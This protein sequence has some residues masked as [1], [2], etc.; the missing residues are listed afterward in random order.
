MSVTVYCVKTE[1][2]NGIVVCRDV[3]VLNEVFYMGVTPRWSKRYKPGT[4]MLIT[5]DGTYLQIKNL[6]EYERI[7]KPFGFDLFYT[8]YL[9]NTN[10]IDRIEPSKHGNVAFFKGGGDITAPVSR[11]KTDEYRHLIRGPLS[12][13]LGY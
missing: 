12:P 2:V 5:L 10:L 7:L 1:P 11:P 6:E 13:I 9:V 3:D 8:S 4:P